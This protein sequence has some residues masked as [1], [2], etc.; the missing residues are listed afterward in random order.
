M[1]RVL[2]LTTLL[3]D[4]QFLRETSAPDDCC[5]V[6]IN[7]TVTSRV[8]RFHHNALLSLSESWPVHLLSISFIALTP[9][10]S[11]SAMHDLTVQ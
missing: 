7:D 10:A 4:V 2:G 11:N 8:V 3:R 1:A 5:T 6:R 9:T